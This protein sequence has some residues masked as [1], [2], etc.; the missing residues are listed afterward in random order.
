MNISFHL[1]HK[2]YP[3]RC[4]NRLLQFSRN[5]MQKY[6]DKHSK[7]IANDANIEIYHYLKCR[8]LEAKTNWKEIREDLLNQSKNITSV[9][10]DAMTLHYCISHKYFNAA[11]DYINH[12]KEENIKL[13]LATLG[14]YFRLFYEL[15]CEGNLTQEQKQFIWSTY[16]DLQKLHKVLDP[17]TNENVIYALSVTENWRECLTLLENTKIIA[18]PTAAAYSVTIA[19]AFYNGDYLLGWQLLDEMLSKYWLII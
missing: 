14:K 1:Q 6:H 19:A 15:H 3:L 4:T 13:N 18:M 16:K 7:P 12:L 11:F 8:T 2:L 10:I 17:N 9:N 5:M